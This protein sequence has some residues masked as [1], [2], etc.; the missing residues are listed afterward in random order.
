[1]AI[2]IPTYP[3][4]SYV[5]YAKVIATIGLLVGLVYVVKKIRSVQKT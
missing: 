4:A 1:M 3:G 5:L 2:I